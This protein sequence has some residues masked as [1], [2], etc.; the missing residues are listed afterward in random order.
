MAK[1][2]DN[3]HKM[4]TCCLTITTRGASIESYK[5]NKAFIGCMQG[6]HGRFSRRET[7]PNVVRIGLERNCYNLNTLRIEIESIPFVQLKPNIIRV[8]GDDDLRA[9]ESSGFACNSAIGSLVCVA[10]NPLKIDTKTME[11]YTSTRLDSTNRTRFSVREEGKVVQI[12]RPYA[13]RQLDLL[14]NVTPVKFLHEP[15]QSPARYCH[16]NHKIPAIVFSSGGFTGNLFHEFNEIIIPL[17]ITSRLFKSRVQFILVDYSPYF[18]AKFNRVLSSLSS[19]DVLNP[20]T[21]TTVHCFPGA[22]VG[23]EYHSFLAINSSEIPKGN[24]MIEFKNFLGETYGLT[25]IKNVSDSGLKPP[26]LLLI[27]R[28]KTRRFLNE[29][30]MVDMMEELGFEVVVV[31]SDKTMSNL[32]RFAKLVSTC[33]VLVG[34]HGAGITNQVFLAAGAVV[35]QVVPLGLE[36]P[37]TVYFGEPA[38][39]MGLRYLDYKIEP[40]E[41]TLIE[42]YAR[43][44]PVISNPGSVFAKGYY[45]GKEMYLDKQNIRVDIGRFKS[46]IIEALRLLGRTSP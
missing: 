23:L 17:F 18:V 6:Y 11:I 36:W 46:T 10:S 2:Y 28:R 32:D 34:A 5:V 12:I 37:S 27:S 38:V 45:I 31:K 1:P 7:N 24:S 19:F 21:N 26:V 30:E 33:S 8:T 22:V 41:S 4:V 20:T 9:L 29:D 16:Y 35:V 15:P 3:R 14:E 43:A 25:T 39:R 13:W 44:D 42:S 40:E